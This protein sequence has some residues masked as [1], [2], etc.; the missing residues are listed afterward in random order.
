M[1][2]RTLS[3]CCV[4]AHFAHQLGNIVPMGGA[5]SIVEELQIKLTL[6]W[7]L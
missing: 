1:G 5:A 7:F 4:L 6:G 2:T 3:V